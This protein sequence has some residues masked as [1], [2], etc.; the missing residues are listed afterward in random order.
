MFFLITITWLSNTIPLYTLYIYIYMYIY[1]Y[2]YGD[3]PPLAPRRETRLPFASS[4][5][6]QC[7]A[8][9]VVDTKAHSNTQVRKGILCLPFECIHSLWI[10]NHK[11]LKTKDTGVN[12]I[13]KSA[14]L[15]PGPGRP[16]VP[17]SFKAPNAGDKAD[18]AKFQR[19]E[20]P[21]WTRRAISAQSSKAWFVL[22]DF[23]TAWYASISSQ[24]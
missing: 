11:V 8:L 4:L 1:I 14:R 13:I 24:A 3:S 21:S 19:M 15:P 5:G 22:D 9:T 7:W 16:T 10:W 6:F 17:E 12:S 18:S 2:V 20:K 23:H